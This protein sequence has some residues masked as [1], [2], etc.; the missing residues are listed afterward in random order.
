MSGQ[1]K[2]RQTGFEQHNGGQRRC[3]N[4][5]LATSAPCDRGMLSL[6]H[7]SVNT[8]NVQ[9]SHQS[10]ALHCSL[11]GSLQIMYDNSMKRYEVLSPLVTV[12]CSP[13]VTAT[14]TP[15]LIPFVYV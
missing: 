8:S 9:R 2:N 5:S 4:G 11:L 3:T 1:H 15:A 10:T 13:S 7:S 14:V 12:P 6:C